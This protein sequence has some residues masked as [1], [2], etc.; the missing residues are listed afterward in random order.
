MRPAAL[1][2]AAAALAAPAAVDAQTLDLP[3]RKAGL[4]EIATTVE[5]PKGAPAFTAKVCIN[6]ATDR[7]LMD[8]GLKLTG[9][10]CK[11]VTTRRDRESL[12]IDTDCTVGGKAARSH[13][14]ITGDLQSAYTLRLEGTMDGGS[15]GPQATV[16][17]QAATWKSADCPGMKPGDMTM[18]GGIKVNIKQL[19]ALSGLIQ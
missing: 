2:L 14:V 6:A 15:K 16:M 1:L 3:P 19:K 8:Y 7:E 12:I 13:T 5:K 11:S 17:T 18:F 4:W 10:S 9:N